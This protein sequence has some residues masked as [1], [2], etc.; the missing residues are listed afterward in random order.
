VIFED[1][2]QNVSALLDFFGS[3]GGTAD[4]LVEPNLNAPRLGVLIQFVK[5]LGIL[6]SCGLL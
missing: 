6:F 5:Q 4:G 2:C 3:E 1:P